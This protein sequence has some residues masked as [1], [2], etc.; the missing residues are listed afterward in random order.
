MNDQELFEKQYG[1]NKIVSKPLRQYLGLRN[2]FKGLDLDRYEACIQLTTGGK[3]CLDIGCNNGFLLRRLSRKFGELYGVDASPSILKEA[4]KKTKEQL[5]KEFNRFNYI[6]KNVNDGLPFSDG[7]FDMVISVAT[8]QYVFDLFKLVGEINRVLISGGEVIVQ[9]PN[10]AYLLRRL[11]LLRGYLP[12]TSAAVNW[13]EVGWDSGSIHYFT[14]G[15]LCWLFE[16]NGFKIVTKSGSGFLAKF[17]NW[18]PSLLSSD[19][20]IRAEKI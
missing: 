20:I 17:R 13:Q 4:E 9:V 7:F 6:H 16:T 19:L 12:V 15:K 5:S 3:R 18:W 8:L 14:M 1:Q 2:F 10:L 11:S